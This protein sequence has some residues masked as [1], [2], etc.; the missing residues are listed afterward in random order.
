VRVVCAWCQDERKPALLREVEP[1]DDPTETHGI[2]AEHHRLLLAQVLRQAVPAAEA[3][4]E[5]VE[6]GLA[7]LGAWV[8][9]GRALVMDPLRDA[10]EMTERAAQRCAA[11]EAERDR[12]EAEVARL[13]QAVTA[14]RAENEGLHALER[15]TARLVGV[16][17]DR[18]L[19]DWVQPL[20]A[21]A[22]RLQSTPRR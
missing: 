11:A 9:A 17:L 22:R 8:A 5:G 18:A 6:A 10:T 21:L 14:V 4:P 3:G 12:L 7:R 1:F 20:H 13:R 2:C 15:E 16:L 19:E